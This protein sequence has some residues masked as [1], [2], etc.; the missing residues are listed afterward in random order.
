[1]RVLVAYGSKRGGTAGLAQ[2]IGEDLRELGLQTDVR[3]ARY[4][5]PP[6][7]YDAVVVAGAL[8][9]RRWHRDAR[10]YVRRNAK[11]LRSLPVWLVSSG[12][13]DD[14][15]RHGELAPAPQVVKAA[16][17]IGA[18]GQTTFGG[19]LAQDAAGF[20]ASSMAK[21]KAGD[22]RS[23]AQVADFVGAMVAYL[24]GHPSVAAGA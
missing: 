4:A 13:L 15:A 22:W 5:E 16:A 9:A 21:T 10:R 11:A 24:T 12:P 20:P 6:D 19:F 7:R 14:S 17:S 18:R 2:M 3:P 1:M 8:Y 23:P